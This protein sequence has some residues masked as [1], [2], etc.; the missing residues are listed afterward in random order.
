MVNLQGIGDLLMQTPLFE[1]MKQQEEYVFV[2]LVNG[3]NA[4]FM[5]KGDRNLQIRPLTNGL[6]EFFKTAF[7]LRREGFD[8]AVNLFGAENSAFIT[9]FTGAGF[10]L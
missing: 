9:A 3:G 5:E 7:A 4:G 6:A 8:I 2:L 1:A 10:V